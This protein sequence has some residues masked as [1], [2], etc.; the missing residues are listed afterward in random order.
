MSDIPRTSYVRA[1]PGVDTLGCGI[2]RC[3]RGKDADT[4]SGQLQQGGLKGVVQRQRLK[5][6]EDLYSQ[7]ASD[8]CGRDTHWRM[9]RNNH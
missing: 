7:Y 9:V 6:P 1:V 8:D 5:A 4:L 2:K 3:M